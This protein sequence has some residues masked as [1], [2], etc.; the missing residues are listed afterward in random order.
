M[1]ASRAAR[2]TMVLKVQQLL[3]PTEESLASLTYTYDALLRLFTWPLCDP[4]DIDSNSSIAA[5][6][7]KHRRYCIAPHISVTA[8]ASVAKL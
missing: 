8:V 1:A 5:A 6:Y 3:A 4:Y 2:Q 7:G